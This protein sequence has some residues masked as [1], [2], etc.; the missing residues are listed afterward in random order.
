M[1]RAE[2]E[3]LLNLSAQNFTSRGLSTEPP[4]VALGTTNQ[5]LLSPMLRR[6]KF[7]TLV[8]PNLK[9]CDSLYFS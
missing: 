8:L 1:F 5:K 4:Y 3:F 7:G 2:L 9:I 6:T